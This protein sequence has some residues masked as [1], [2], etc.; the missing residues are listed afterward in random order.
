M[1]LSEAKIPYWITGGSLLGALRH[2]GFIPHDDDVD[3]ECFEAFFFWG[4]GLQISRIEGSQGCLN[5]GGGGVGK[6]GHVNLWLICGYFPRRWP[7]FTR[8]PG[9]WPQCLQE[10]VGRIQGAFASSV[11]VA[12]NGCCYLLMF[13][14]HPWKS[15]WNLKTTSLKR[16]IIFQPSMFGFNMLIFPGVHF[17]VEFITSKYFLILLGNY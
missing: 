12:V 10:D 5:K 4:G 2:K 15:T 13:V 3:L 6:I 14:L 8:V 16:K 11:L 9:H 7:V 1:K 17:L